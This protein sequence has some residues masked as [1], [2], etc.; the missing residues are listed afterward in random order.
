ME[1]KPENCLDCPFHKVIADPDPLDWF[2][3]DDQAV[4][5]TKVNRKPNMNSQYLA[6]KQEFKTVTVSCRPYK[7]RVESKTPDWCPL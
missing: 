3:D 4:I 1:K 2:N 5:C 7:L 6:D